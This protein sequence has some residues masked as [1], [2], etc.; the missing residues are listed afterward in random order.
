MAQLRLSST[1]GTGGMLARS[2][3]INDDTKIVEKYKSTPTSTDPLVID[4]KDGESV[5]W[6]FK[7]PR[8]LPLYGTVDGVSTTMAHTIPE[9]EQNPDVPLAD[10]NTARSLT[11][12]YEAEYGLIEYGYGL[13][14]PEIAVAD[15][16]LLLSTGDSLR[17]IADY[18]SFSVPAYSQNITN[19]PDSDIP[20]PD[21][22]G[23]PTG[24]E[25]YDGRFYVVDSNQ[26][27][28]RFKY[29]AV[30]ETVDITKEL[31]LD[32]AWSVNPVTLETTRTGKTANH[33]D[34]TCWNGKI[35]IADRS[36]GNDQG[37]KALS[38]YNISDGSKEGIF[39]INFPTGFPGGSGN[40][41]R[42]YPDSVL[43]DQKRNRMLIF[44]R[45]N[46]ADEFV[47]SYD[48]RDEFLNDSI[49]NDNPLTGVTV[50][51]SALGI[52]NGV[53]NAQS[54]YAVI[55]TND[56]LYVMN[57]QST[58][59][60]GDLENQQNIQFAGSLNAVCNGITVWRGVILVGVRTAGN[61]KLRAILPRNK[62]QK[63]TDTPTPDYSRSPHGGVNQ[64]GES[65][66][67]VTAD[68]IV[69]DYD[70]VKIVPDTTP[71]WR[72]EPLHAP[73]IS[74]YMIDQTPRWTER[75]KVYLHNVPLPDDTAGTLTDDTISA[76]AEKVKMEL[77]NPVSIADQVWRTIFDATN[78][79]PATQYPDRQVNTVA[80]FL[81][82][83]HDRI[84][85]NK[86]VIDNT[87][88]EVDKIKAD[89]TSLKTD[90]AGVN[91]KSTEIDAIKSQTDKMIFNSQNHIRM[92]ERVINTEITTLSTKLSQVKTDLE[93][94]IDNN[95][96][97]LRP[98]Q[99]T[100]NALTKEVIADAV[101]AISADVGFGPGKTL[102]DIVNFLGVNEIGN[103]ELIDASDDLVAEKSLAVGYGI[104]DKAGA[105]R[106][107]KKAKTSNDIDTIPLSD[108]AVKLVR[109]EK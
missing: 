11:L 42:A 24:V 31:V 105:L 89:T 91:T 6:W 44:C 34:L 92:D 19:H 78:N 90:L 82:Q 29:E 109:G 21:P 4:F 35:Y 17:M 47:L 76:I 77:P 85:I 43:I 59:Y 5:R 37:H 13:D 79:Q 75:G 16:D 7:A 64:I 14:R 108:D 57:G 70:F 65:P 106:Y 55:D 100:L 48:L 84:G 3:D 96:N 93:G 9:P 69:I 66:I 99:A 1:L 30:D 72:R 10:T 12:R 20:L 74:R 2:V 103:E 40:R 80:Y 25:F 87:K 15:I 27:L 46:S 107:T 98:I 32:D 23:A 86:T 26:K 83:A 28:F 38:V 71:M 45:N 73:L 51:H 39:T 58:I 101:W 63:S 102:K 18:D 67:Q 8:H 41:N 52:P 104:R 54:A 88:T 33:G 60:L 81:K 49:T 68:G 61:F 94:D 53:F 62:S 56:V 36:T 95:E 97:Y 50:G 22:V